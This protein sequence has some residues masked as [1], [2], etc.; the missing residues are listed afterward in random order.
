MSGRKLSLPKKVAEMGVPAWNSQGSVR[1]VL[2]ILDQACQAST[3]EEALE[4]VRGFESLGHLIWSYAYLR[5]LHY[6]DSDLF[7]RLLLAEPSFLMPIV[8]TPTVGEACQKFGTLPVLPRGCYVSLTDRGNVRA[9]LKEYADAM[10]PKGADGK[11]ECQCIVFSDGGRILGL[12][13]LGVWGMGIPIGKLD[14]Y[15]VCGGFDPN[16]TIPVIIDAGCDDF[17]PHTNTAKPKQAIRDHP[18]YHGLKQERVKHTA[19]GTQ[20]NSAYYGEE[21]LIGEFMTAA[22]DL[23]GQ[24]CLLQFE[25]FNTNDAFPLLAEYRDR[26]LTYNDDIQGTASVTVAAVLGGIKLQNPS[27]TN[28]LEELRGLRVLFHGAGSANL[29][30]AQLIISAAKMPKAQVLVTNSRGVIWASESG[31]TYRNEQQKFVAQEGEPKGYDH[32]DLVSIIKHHKPDILVGAV[33]RAPNC[34]TQDVVKAMVSVQDEKSSEAEKRRP[35]IFALSNPKSQAELTAEDCYRF[36]EGRAIF[37][38]GTRFDCVANASGTKCPGQV[39]N[40]FIFPGMSFGAVCCEATTIPDELFMTA[41][42]A[43]AHSLDEDDRKSESVLPCTARIREVGLKVATAVVLAA[44]EAGLARKKLGSTEEE[45]AKALRA[46]RWEPG[47]KEVKPKADVAPLR[48]RG[49]RI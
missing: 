20:V 23:F 38:S 21:S 13:D 35:V 43:V 36:S 26:F 19:K 31:G 12:G 22:R 32:T 10:L 24:G 17:A 5:M 48:L 6:K 16:K 39:N 11:P 47:A 3:V 34:F 37:G 27:A 42:E 1:H 25:D 49:S 2:Q 29:G 33:G 15:T 40:F 18:L 41:A 45:V 8:Y 30:S 9:V 28:L 14:L 4:E 46:L 7:Y 44:Q